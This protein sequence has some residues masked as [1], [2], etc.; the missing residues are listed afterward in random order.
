[1]NLESNKKKLFIETNTTGKTSVTREN[2]KNKNKQ[3]ITK[4]TKLNTSSVIQKIIDGRRYRI[5]SNKRP[6]SN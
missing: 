4:T 2:E 6:T 1:M 3:A 5:Y